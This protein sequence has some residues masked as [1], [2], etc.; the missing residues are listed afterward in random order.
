VRKGCVWKGGVW[1]W[2]DNSI[3]KIRKPSLKLEYGIGNEVGESEKVKGGEL[4]PSFVPF[5]ME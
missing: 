1:M 2:G 3:L 5:R 4:L